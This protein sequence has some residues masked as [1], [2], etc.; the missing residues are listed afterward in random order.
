MNTQ[1]IWINE[2]E[3]FSSQAECEN[4]T[5]NFTCTSCGN[6]FNSSDPADDLL[7]LIGGTL[8][9]AMALSGYIG[10]LISIY[11]LSRPRI[12][13]TFNRLLIV[14]AYFDASYIFLYILDESMILIDYCTN[15]ESYFILHSSFYL[16]LFVYFLYP[17]QQIFQTSSIFMIVI[18]SIDRYVAI[19]HP[20]YVDEANSLIRTFLLG[21]TR[22]NVIL[23]ISTIVLFST[24]VCFPHFLEFSIVDE[25][26]ILYLAFK[27]RQNFLF[28]LLYRACFD[29]LIRI[30]LPVFI[31]HKNYRKIFKVV[32]S[33]GSK[34]RFWTLY[35]I[36]MVFI[37]CNSGKVMVNCLEI[38]NFQDIQICSEFHKD[39]SLPYWDVVLNL[40]GIENDSDFNVQA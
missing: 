10:N 21:P 35:S 9:F 38:M 2:N 29:T 24:I 3:S 20:F 15:E 12:I 31:L 39:V 37:V 6:A 27:W 11:V 22:R 33:E 23:Y 26:P 28:C 18:I 30:F 14:L 40:T 1:Q 25:E 13:S 19:I 17:F 8:P 36:V 5:I 4:K 7:F 16:H 34:S 32:R